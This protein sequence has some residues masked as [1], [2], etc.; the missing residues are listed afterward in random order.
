MRQNSVGALPIRLDST[1]SPA[2]S[3]T[4]TC[5]RLRCRSTPTYTM[6][7]PPSC[8]LPEA[9]ATSRP[10][11]AAEARSFMASTR[12]HV[13]TAMVSH[14]VPVDHVG[15]LALERAA[16]LLGG[17]GLAQLTLVVDLS[18]AGVAD[19]ADRDEMQGSGELPVA[20]P[21]Q[22]VAAHIPAGGFD[23]GV[24]VELAKW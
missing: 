22:P 2:G 7:G 24:P 8:R 21:V 17:L 4:T 12:G 6:T 15:E 10:S 23:G 16:G 14:Q 5:E 11:T 18:W 20:A 19:L 13:V 1:T 3:R 9:D